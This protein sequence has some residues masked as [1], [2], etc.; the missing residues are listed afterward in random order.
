MNEINKVELAS[1]TAMAYVENLALQQKVEHSY[2]N[3]EEEYVF[4]PD[5][6]IIFDEIYMLIIH[7]IEQ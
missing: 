1:E 4:F 3:D 2:P 7:K 5:W 6:Q